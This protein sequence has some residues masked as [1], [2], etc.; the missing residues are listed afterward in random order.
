MGDEATIRLTQDLKVRYEVRYTRTAALELLQLSGDLTPMDEPQTW[1]D[2]LIGERLALAAKRC[3]GNNPLFDQL[4]QDAGEWKDTHDI[5][6][7]RAG[8]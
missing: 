6:D 4:V 3:G 5:S 8:R 1:S 7:W 2:A